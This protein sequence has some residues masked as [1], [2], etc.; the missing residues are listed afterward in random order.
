M[1][2]QNLPP[3]T[4]DNN[5]GA[6]QIPMSTKI[7]TALKVFCILSIIWCSLSMLS[8]AYGIKYL[9]QSDE[10][11]YKEVDNMAIVYEK[12]GQSI[13]TESMFTQLKNSGLQN[14]INL[15]LN[16]FSLIGVIW[17]LK[18]MK[19]GLI[20]YAIAELL[21]WLSIFLF[22]GLDGLKNNPGM[23]M[24]GGGGMV[25]IVAIFVFMIIIDL[26]FIFLYRHF[27]NQHHAN[28]DKIAAQTV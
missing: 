1:E 21:P 22:G 27:L 18:G 10:S 9:F 26:V 14:L 2:N 11:I 12:M 20:V 24:F 25:I 6:N 19:K 13:D 3:N 7:P 28:L 5:F 23:K 15:V 4:F 17:M 16:V 8:S